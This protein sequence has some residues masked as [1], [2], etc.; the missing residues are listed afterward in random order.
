MLLRNLSFRYKLP[1]CI[2]LAST[3]TASVAIMV[4]SWQYYQDNKQALI[5]HSHELGGSMVDML[6]WSVKNNDIWHAY[7]LL[8]GDKKN[9]LSTPIRA[10]ILLDNQKTVF[11]SNHPNEFPVGATLSD[12]ATGPNQYLNN[13]LKIFDTHKET[14]LS[15]DKHLISALPVTSSGISYGSLLII[16]SYD[17]I[18][19]LFKKTSLLALFVVL[20]TICALIPVAWLWGK[21]I[22]NPLLS[23]ESCISK[24]GKVPFDEIQCATTYDNDE[25]GQLGR[26][27]E[28]MVSELKKKSELENQIIRA[29][30]L[31]TAGTLAAGVAHE[32]NNPLAGM[33]MAVDTYKQYCRSEDCHH[34]DQARASIDLVERGLAQIK[35]TVSALLVNVNAK[36]KPLT[37]IEIED[38]FTLV[39]PK[40][41]NKSI[42]FEWN[43][44]IHNTINIS[45][46]P[47][48]QVLINLLLNAIEATAPN[49]S[50]SS[51]IHTE[52]NTLIITI[53]NDGDEMT[54]EQLEHLFE[55]F[56][57]TKQSGNG[58]GLWVTYQIVRNLGGSISVGR[59]GTWTIFDIILPITS[60]DITE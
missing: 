26:Q 56:Y 4:V 20:L 33:L 60:K 39:M 54:A 1:F 48:R 58:L 9:A 14:T 18:V 15:T 7:T 23:L 8:R 52:K 57:T 35:E 50:I 2:I 55:P 44:G 45:A 28:S 47:V 43:N 38:V 10:L 40:T 46:S 37:P 19:A 16:D 17:S 49:G 22:T 36:D 13:A 25:I 41:H 30:R 32:I 27:F 51:H 24:V 6:S 53:K 3:L 42:T 34:R 21:H 29:D 11:A 59:I 12:I 31:A 5:Q